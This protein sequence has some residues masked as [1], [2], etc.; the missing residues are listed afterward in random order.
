M[1]EY[2]E[3]EFYEQ[4]ALQL[5]G[6]AKQI[7]TDL[8]EQNWPRIKDKIYIQFKHLTNKDILNSQLENLKQEKDESLTKFA[9]RARKLLQEKNAAYK[10]LTEDQKIE[11]KSIF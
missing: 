9:E 10:Y 3:N 6:E 2:E 1:N 8:R 7:L 4:M 5:R 11:H